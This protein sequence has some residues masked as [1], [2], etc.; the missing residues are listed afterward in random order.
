MV[1]VGLETT[2]S[3]RDTFVLILLEVQVEC[4]SPGCKERSW[5]TRRVHRTNMVLGIG[6]RHD[7]SLFVDPKSFSLSPPDGPELFSLF[8]T[9]R[10]TARLPTERSF[11]RPSIQSF[12]G[13]LRLTDTRRSLWESVCVV[14]SCCKATHLS[15]GISQTTTTVSISVFTTGTGACIGG[16]V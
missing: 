6:A 3:R 4:F 9:R 10:P 13:E 5:Q 7:Q 16:G 15:D 1:E 14:N 11:S 12:A 8:A 2:T